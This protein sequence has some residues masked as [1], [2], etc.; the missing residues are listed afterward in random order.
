MYRPTSTPRPEPSQAPAPSSAF[1]ATST[2]ESSFGRQPG[3][4]HWGACRH[5]TSLSTSFSTKAN[6]VPSSSNHGCTRR[7]RRPRI[8]DYFIKGGIGTL[9]RQNFAQFSLSFHSKISQKQSTSASQATYLCEV[10]PVVTFLVSSSVPLTS[11]YPPCVSH[12]WIVA[13]TSP[14]TIPIRSALTTYRRSP[15]TSPTDEVFALS[16]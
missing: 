12:S 14:A 11:P 10:V 13:Y 7:L 3:S 9:R 2:A 5:P 8:V 15:T 1:S 6:P 16:P 4:L